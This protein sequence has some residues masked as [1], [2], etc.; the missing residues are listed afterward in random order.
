MRETLLDNSFSESFGSENNLRRYFAAELARSGR[1]DISMESMNSLF[2][3]LPRSHTFHPNFNNLTLPPSPPLPLS[4]NLALPLSPM[5][6]MPSPSY[7]TAVTNSPPNVTSDTRQTEPRHT[8][9]TAKVI[10]PSSFWMCFSRNTSIL[11]RDGGWVRVSELAPKN[12]PLIFTFCQ[13]T[14]ED[15]HLVADFLDK[16]GNIITAKVSQDALFYVQDKGWCSL[17]PSVAARKYKVQGFM[18][19]SPGDVCQPVADQEEIVL[20]QQGAAPTT[21]PI[22]AKRPMNSFMLFAKKYRLELTRL[23][24]GK[25]NRDISILLGERWRSLSQEDKRRY[26]KEAQS[27]AEINKQNNPN[28]WKRRSKAK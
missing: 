15:E 20:S 24:P 6:T 5:F 16:P 10:L 14:L 11:K 22:R 2:P 25:D 13:Y 27:L 12:L 19:L 17:L 3:S 28:C 4:P 8:E 26:A 21:P 9:P 18:F 1:K 23:H 7:L